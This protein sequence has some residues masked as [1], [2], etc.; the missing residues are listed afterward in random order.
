MERE[1]IDKTV[2]FYQNEWS[3]F[4]FNA[5]LES[6]KNQ[7]SNLTI[8]NTMQKIINGIIHTNNQE[9]L[10]DQHLGPGK[11]RPI[12]TK[13][14]KICGFSCVNGNAYRYQNL[15][16]SMVLIRKFERLIETEINNLSGAS[17]SSSSS[18]APPS[19]PTNQAD[20]CQLPLH[21]PKAAPPSNLT[22]Q[23]DV[24]QLLLHM[25]CINST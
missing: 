20:V 16:A 14:I 25:L 17:S 1:E 7:Q 10:L 5:L 23:A 18:A 19:N 2:E 3:E 21:M 15:L 9:L 8:L 22:N 11:N 24:C 12:L 6:I 4:Y 13:F